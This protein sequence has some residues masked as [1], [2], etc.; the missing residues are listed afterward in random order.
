MQEDEEVYKL[1]MSLKKTGLVNNLTE[2]LEKAREIVFV[3]RKDLRSVTKQKFME[4]LQSTA[5]GE[6]KTV[7]IEGKVIPE[8]SPVEKQ[9]TIIE[10]V[11][12]S[13]DITQT[14]ESQPN[15]VEMPN[16]PIAFVEEAQ[17]EAPIEET[18]M[19]P[20]EVMDQPVIQAE[21]PQETLLDEK[22]LPET[23]TAEEVIANLDISKEEM[24]LKELL[25]EDAEEI[26]T[27]V[28]T[29]K[30]PEALPDAK[31]AEISDEEDIIKESDTEQ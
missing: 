19:V 28:A 4:A 5:I 26:Y 25:D 18:V 17:Q 14:I 7:E 1:A 11:E 9:E 3:E 15:I 29:E 21:A 10:A 31:E 23:K 30:K 6:K 20:E 16:E 24:V 8:V 12:S 13:S 2:A 27:T 22:I